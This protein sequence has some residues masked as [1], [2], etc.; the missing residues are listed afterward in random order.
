MVRFKECTIIGT[1]EGGDAI[2]P[3]V[4]GIYMI[5]NTITNKCYI[6][7][8]VNIRRRWRRH[9]RTL[10]SD[11]HH[12]LHLQRAWDKYGKENFAFSVLEYVS[13]EDLLIKE[14]Y[15]MDA[16][17]S[18]NQDKGYNICKTAGNML[19]FKFTLASRELLSKV[20]TGRKHSDETKLKISLVH[21]GKKMNF[22]Q[23][24]LDNL[25]NRSRNSVGE[26][27]PFYGRTHSKESKAKISASLKGRKMPDDFIES[28][29]GKGNP[30]Y[31][32]THSME[33]RQ[34]IGDSKRGKK[35]PASFSENQLGEKNPNAKLTEQQVVEIKRLL[36]EGL[37][38]HNIASLYNVSRA[39]IGKI[40]TGKC[41]GHVK[42]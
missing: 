13:P 33:T 28:R 38:Q 42:V 15:W 10:N 30:F 8:A 2:I 6:G 18:Y 9:L 19:G 35:L 37:A 31:G 24:F 11:T 4:S 41:W 7:S 20:R 17:K 16:Y 23:E 5:L 29:R 27:N 36:Q 1:H 14:Q 40:H 26:L 39:M 21:K 3:M 12:N 25:S 32:R 22:T 34:K